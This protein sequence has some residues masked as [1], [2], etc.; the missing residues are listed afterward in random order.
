[1]QQFPH[2]AM[3][4]KKISATPA[5]ESALPGFTAAEDLPPP[6]EAVVVLKGM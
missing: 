3:L 5:A 4:S 2:I 6:E 1:M